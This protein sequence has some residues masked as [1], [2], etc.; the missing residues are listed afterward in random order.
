MTLDAST[1]ING[2]APLNLSMS[3]DMKA[4]DGSFT[5]GGKLG[6]TPLTVFN[7]MTIHN[8]NIEVREG[9]C[10]SLLFN[11]K[12]EDKVAYG[13]MEFRYEDLKVFM[14]KDPSKKGSGSEKSLL[15]FFANTFVINKNNPHL[16]RFREASEVHLDC[17]LNVGNLRGSLVGTLAG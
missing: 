13:N 1:L 6:A 2:Q 4:K 9:T 14:L 3:F 17:F 8:A 11:I 7:D 5:V 12:A 15:S 16:F 10:N